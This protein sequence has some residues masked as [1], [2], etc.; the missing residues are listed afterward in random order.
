MANKIKWLFT[1][2]CLWWNN[3]SVA[4]IPVEIFA[5]HQKTTLDIMFFKFFK[6]K[7]ENSP[8][9]FFNRNRASI[10]YRMTLTDH[11]PQFG[12]TEA[13][14]YN[15]SKLK[16][17]AP[18]VVAQILNRG[19]YPKAGIQYALV[20]KN[21][22]FFSWLVAETL[23]KPSIDFFVLF[24]Y[25]PHLHKQLH[26]FLQTESANTF[27]TNQTNPFS[28]TQR[29]RLGLKLKGWQSGIGVDFNQIAQR[30]SFAFT[31]N[32]GV[33]LRYEF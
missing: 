21:T 30:Q 13:V 15:H 12:F 23:A 17:F 20:K 32:L 16:G 7:N 24:R 11:L 5:G 33:F 31:Y 2:F 26:L 14:S 3:S 22:T 25:S 27:P 1:F 19:L 6:R 29:L 9:L 4:Q 8:W 28:F 10:D 18:V